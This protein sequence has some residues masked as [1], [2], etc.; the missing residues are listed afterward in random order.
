MSAAFTG[1]NSEIGIEFYRGIMAYLEHVN[2][3]GG[4]NGRRIEIMPAND[5]YNPSPSFRNTLRFAEE[6]VFALFSYVGTPTTTYVLPLLEKFNNRDLYL[7]FPLSGSQPLRSQPYYQYV[8]NLRPSYFEET[9]SLVHKLIETGRKRIAVFYQNDAYGRTG[10]DG[11]RRALKGYGL[12]MASD[13]AYARGAELDSNFTEEVRLIMKS[14]PDAI[15]CAGTYAAQAAFIRDLRDAGHTLPVAG[16]SFDDSDKM[17]DLLIAE[18]QRKNRDYTTR[19]LNTQVVPSYEATGY[20]TVRLYRM[21]MAEYRETPEVSGPEYIP[22]RFSH[23]S[24][25]GFLNAMLL[26]EMVR[27]MG[28]KP[29]RSRIP[30]ALASIRGFDLGIGEP[31]S[32]GSGHQ[33]LHEIYFTTVRDGAFLPVLNWARWRK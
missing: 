4:V 13:A 27:R 31:V 8:Y 21:L 25:E 18:G 19:L 6:D 33:G 12:P 24:F 32:F 9:A 7:L 3:N 17:L 14:E 29:D 16:L 28:D 22:R 15:I 30:E 11:V 2:A 23:V 26:V 1:A 20:R 10:W 5:G